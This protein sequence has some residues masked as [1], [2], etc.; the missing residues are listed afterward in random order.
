MLLPYAMTMYRVGFGGVIE[1]KLED[2]SK[3]VVS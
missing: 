3:S 2:N 1:L